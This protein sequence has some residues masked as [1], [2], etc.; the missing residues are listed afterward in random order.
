MGLG[1]GRG[2]SMSNPHI[3]IIIP[4]VR[5]EKAARCVEAI[6][7]KDNVIACRVATHSHEDSWSHPGM[8][9]KVPDAVHVEADIAGPTGDAVTCE[10]LAAEDVDRIGCP[11]MVAKLTAMARG[12][13]VMFLGDDTIPQPGF[14]RSA[15]EAMES[16]PDGWGLVALNDGIHNGHLA[17]HWL[18]SKRLLEHL[19][20]GEFFHTGYRHCFCDRELTDIARELGRYV[21]A[22]EAKIIHDHPQVTGAQTDEHY[23]RVYSQEVFQADQRTYWRRKRDRMGFKLGVGIPL[24]DRE[25]NAQFFL[26]FVSMMPDAYTL[27]VPRFPAG[28][29]ADSIASVRNDLVEQALEAGCSHLLMCDTDQVYP[30]DTVAKLLSHKKDIVG[31]AVHR[32]WPPFDLVMLRGELGK[33]T[34]VPED[35]CYSGNLVSVDATGTGCLLID[36][37]VFIDMPR[38]WFEFGQANGR[39]VGEDILFCSKARDSGFD[40]HVDTSIQVDHLTTLRVNRGMREVYKAQHGHEF[41]TAG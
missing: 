11:A 37:R 20:G 23:Q 8:V 24:A 33:Y 13:H 36:T 26:S 2:T 34:H 30:A 7:S 17:T 35:E 10:V 21:Y 25:V 15:L 40:I 39:P 32:R 29:F 14:L 41:A 27:F 38:P 18:A 16:L 9:V 3:S 12:E 1:G 22:P 19:P 6:V 31:V 28:K 4:V 5:P